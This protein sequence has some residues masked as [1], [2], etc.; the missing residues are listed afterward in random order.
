MPGQEGVDSDSGQACRYWLGFLPKR[1]IKA[2]E[3]C[4]MELKPLATDTS[5]I[6]IC[7]LVNSTLAYCSRISW[8]N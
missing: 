6:D 1:V 4:D 5:R 2:L 8:L 7:V 3:K